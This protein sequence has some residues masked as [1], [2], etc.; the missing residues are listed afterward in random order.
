M[1]VL[2]LG[3]LTLQGFYRYF[4]DNN[5]YINIKYFRKIFNRNLFLIQK[6]HAVEA[7]IQENTNLILR[8]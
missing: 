8:H 3:Q 4:F 2:I 5:E 7:Y 6:N 1:N